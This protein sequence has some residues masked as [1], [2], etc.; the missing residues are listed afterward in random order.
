MS[1]LKKVGNDPYKRPVAERVQRYPEQLSLHL[2]N[3]VDATPEEWKEWR[4]TDFF[5]KGNFDPLLLF[6]VIPTIIQVSAF[7]F[8]LAVFVINGSFLEQK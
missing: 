6:V 4:E 3:T 2:H 8:M 7:F 5:S 1:V